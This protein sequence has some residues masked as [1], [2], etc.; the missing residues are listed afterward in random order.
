MDLDFL[1][2]VPAEGAPGARPSEIDAALQQFL[3]IKQ[4]TCRSNPN[5][6]SQSENVV[7]DTGSFFFPV[8]DHL[9]PGPLYLL[10]W[11]ELLL[12]EVLLEGPVYTERICHLQKEC[13]LDL[14][15]D[16]YPD[17]PVGS[18][19]S[20]I[21]DTQNCSDLGVASEHLMRTADPLP[22]YVA[23]LGGYDSFGRLRVP[24]DPH[25]DPSLSSR[26]VYTPEPGH[27]TR[28][29]GD[30]FEAT[31]D[32][33]ESQT[34]EDFTDFHYQGAAQYRIG[35]TRPPT[36][37][38]GTDALGNV[39]PREA[40]IQLQTTVSP[41]DM[42]TAPPGFVPQPTGAP[43]SSA[44]QPTSFSSASQAQAP[45]G[46][47]S[48]TYQQAASAPAAPT[49]AAP[50]PAPTY[51]I[52]DTPVGA[53]PPSYSAPPPAPA[54]TPTPTPTPPPAPAAPMS[55]PSYSSG[56]Y[57]YSG[58]YR[59]LQMRGR[60]V[61]DSSAS[62]RGRGRVARSRHMD[63]RRLVLGR[64]WAIQKRLLEFTH[65]SKQFFC[66]VF[67]HVVCWLSVVV[68]GIPVGGFI[69]EIV[70]YWARSG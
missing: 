11:G 36:F 37:E 48:S 10:C 14:E 58:Y 30:V 52:P 33:P 65:F 46:A 18:Y 32:L 25:A 45:A 20:L 66:L 53:P 61:E 31:A 60:S 59:S 19:I 49:P 17:F 26:G 39:V 23:Q 3:F 1:R 51:Q 24:E 62:P 28:T 57:G 38:G 2:Y 43:S 34:L 67:S 22:S 8:I 7:N 16:G 27:P 6:I 63:I 13:V 5:F 29:A 41:S 54:P 42:M 40:P 12:A 4:T 21:P 56:G 50:S 9:H 44:S 35:Q 70:V 68:H 64:K 15:G 47:A 69:H 55:T